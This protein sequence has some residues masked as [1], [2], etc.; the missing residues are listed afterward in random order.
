LPAII[1]TLC[2]AMLP[3]PAANRQTNNGNDD[4]AMQ[5]VGAGST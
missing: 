5:L 4:G 3:L 2:W 1:G